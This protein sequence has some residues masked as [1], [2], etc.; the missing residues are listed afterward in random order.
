MIASFVLLA[1]SPINP[2]SLLHVLFI[3]G[4]ALI[5]FMIATR[6][7]LAHGGH[8]L[9]LE[10]RSPTLIALIFLL[11]MAAL[12]RSFGY[13]ALAAAMWLSAIALWFLTVGRKVFDLRDV[14]H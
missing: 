10:I 11:A 13:L 3:L 7:V 12:G 2:L 4:Y 9:Q 1:L 8:S 6:V 5:T 14:S